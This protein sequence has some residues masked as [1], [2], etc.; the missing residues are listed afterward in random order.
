LRGL[1]RSGLRVPKGM[2]I[3]DIDARNDVSACFLVSDK[4]LAIGGGV[5]EA[6]LSKSE[7]RGKLFS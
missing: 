1:I 4:S 6:L 7:I 5:L 3:G 2:K